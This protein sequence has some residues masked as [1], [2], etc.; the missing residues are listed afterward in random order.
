MNVGLETKRL[1]FREFTMD[2]AGLLLD[3]NSDPEVTRYTLDPMLD[4]EQARKV[5]EQAI[6]PQ[7]ALYNYGR[8][9]VHHNL[10]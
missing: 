2:D 9:V 4:I 10:N 1:Y 8:W 5:L 3:L 7:Y 6:L